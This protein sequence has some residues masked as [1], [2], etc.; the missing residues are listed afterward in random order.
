MEFHIPA[1]EAVQEGKRMNIEHALTALFILCIIT[2]LAGFTV[3]VCI[4]S[5]TALE[6][7]EI[8]QILINRLK[9]RTEESE[10]E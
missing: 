9:K 2:L 8:G 4:M 6:D 7:T 3:F 1:A 10:D 5:L